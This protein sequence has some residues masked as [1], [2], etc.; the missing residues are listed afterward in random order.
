M[1]ITIRYAALEDLAAV[2]KVEADCFPAAE[3]A[4]RKSLEQRLRTFPESFLVAETAGE[5][6]G[7]MNGCATNAAAIYDEL[8]EDSALH[9]PDGDYQTIF[10]LNIL[11]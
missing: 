2:T 11:K 8:Y 5:I 9:I 7:F 4:K 1:D 6:I 10:G 3:A